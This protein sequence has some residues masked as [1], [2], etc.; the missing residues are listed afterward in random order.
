M[1]GP[2]FF[3]HFFEKLKCRITFVYNSNRLIE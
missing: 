1:T 2:L 3:A